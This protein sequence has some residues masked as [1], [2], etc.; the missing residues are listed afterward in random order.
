MRIVDGLAFEIR[1]VQVAGNA[2]LVRPHVSDEFLRKHDAVAFDVD[3]KPFG[4]QPH[5]VRQVGVAHL[6]G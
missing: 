4:P 2:E 6:L 3:R 5:T 1:D